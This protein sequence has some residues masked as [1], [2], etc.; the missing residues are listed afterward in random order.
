MI[1]KPRSFSATAAI[2]LAVG[3]NVLMLAAFAS[4][5]SAPEED[6]PPPPETRPTSTAE[7]RKSIEA[8]SSVQE[9]LQLVEEEIAR[10][11]AS[12]ATAREAEKETIEAEIKALT[13]RRNRLR[14][15]FESI[16]TGIDPEE[17]DESVDE[18]FVL[19][20]ELDTLLRPLIEELKDLTEQ[21]REIEK[22]RS[23]LETWK[24]RLATTQGAFRN[25]DRL[26]DDVGD[27]LAE[28][29]A[30]TKRKWSERRKQAQNRI[31]A[32]TYQLEQA[33]RNQPSFFSTI[34]DGVRSFLRSRGRNFILCVLVFF[35]VFLG[36]RYLHRRV[37]QHPAWR[38]K[39]E[40]AFSIRLIDVGLNVFS[41][42]AAVAAALIVLYAT[43]DWVLMGLAIIVLFG[44]ILAAK[45]GLPRFYDQGRLLLNMGEVRE[46]ERV[47]FNGIPWKIERL[48]FFSILTNEQLRGGYVRLPIRH[49]G[50]LISRPVSEHGE[51]WFP[52]DE[53]DWIDLPEEGKG[54]VVAQTP[55]YVQIVKLGGAKITMPTSD[56]LAKSPKNL[57][58][59]FRLST[60]FGIDYRHQAECTTTIPETMREHLIRELTALIE[61]REKLL[62]LKVELKEAGSSSLDY[63]IIADLDG[64]L[65]PKYEVVH[66]AIHR[67]LVDC[68]N[69]NGYVIPFTQ[70]TLH[71][72]FPE[73]EPADDN[74][75]EKPDKKKPRLP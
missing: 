35:G 73:E 66:R 70:V 69:E 25:L 13:T 11:A 1:S 2:G 29:I 53:G 46:G 14:A 36:L 31:Q 9:S 4:A 33:E 43:G 21:P 30:E 27:E 45:N 40:R 51:Q 64:A 61:D 63:A 6:V 23:E 50:E 5:E 15:D 12:A 18:T 62:S 54:R 28:E 26:P 57:S 56:F 59:N 16:A 60:V 32:L 42:L 67:I 55:E 8:L 68:C 10:L 7:M 49:L 39:G 72:A 34:R 41:F 19:T 48:S 38:R 74:P 22:L 52:C 65:A 20:D 3:W 47:V 58:H 24:R 37:A 71:N 75:D 17:Y 44:L